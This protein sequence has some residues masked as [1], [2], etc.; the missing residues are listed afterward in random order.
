[1]TNTWKGPCFCFLLAETKIDFNY[2]EFDQFHTIVEK[3]NN[4]RQNNDRRCQKVDK[5]NFEN[6]RFFFKF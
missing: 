2:V 3:K 6:I 4:D 1:M 5:L